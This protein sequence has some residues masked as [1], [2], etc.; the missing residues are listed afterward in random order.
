MSPATAED[1][2]EDED[3]D[4]DEEEAERDFLLSQK[5][6]VPRLP[7]GGRYS[8]FYGPLAAAPALTQSAAEG[9]V[10]VVVARWLPVPT[11]A[12]P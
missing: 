10:V 5:R 4:D 6:A 9:V 1:D 3:E 12:A 7:L 11:S 8:M 2:D